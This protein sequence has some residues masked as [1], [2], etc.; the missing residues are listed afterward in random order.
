M[1]PRLYL[2]SNISEDINLAHE[3]HEMKT[4]AAAATVRASTNCI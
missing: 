3:V 4:V 1:L 2:I